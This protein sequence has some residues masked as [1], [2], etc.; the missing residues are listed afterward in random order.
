MISKFPGFPL[1]SSPSAVAK[2]PLLPPAKVAV[3]ELPVSV[4]ESEALILTLP[5]SPFLRPAL[6]ITAPCLTASRSV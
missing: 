1:A 4:I 5:P 6:D 3:G 2:I